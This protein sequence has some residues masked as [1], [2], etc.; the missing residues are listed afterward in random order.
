M[1]YQRN[2]NIMRKG[3]RFIRQEN[4]LF[5]KDAGFIAL[6]AVCSKRSEEDTGVNPV[7]QVLLL[8]E[9][10]FCLIFTL[11]VSQVQPWLHQH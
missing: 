6:R 1:C 8:T 4:L 5:F 2:F 9:S 10:I 3:S 7:H 11:Q